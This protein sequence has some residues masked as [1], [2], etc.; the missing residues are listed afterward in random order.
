MKA[1]IFRRDATIRS[2][3]IPRSKRSRTTCW[4]RRRSTARSSSRRWRTSTTESRTNS[5]R[6]AAIS[7]NELKIGI[8]KATISLKFCGVVPG[9]AFKKKGVQR[10]LDCVVDYLPSPLDLPPDARARTARRGRSP[11]PTTTASCLALAFKL[12]SDPFVGKLV[13]FRVYS[14]KLSKGDTVYNPR[15]RQRERICRLMLIRADRARGHRR[16]LLRRHLR[17]GRHQEHHHR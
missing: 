2:G 5:S 16:R 17:H 10:L 14:G 4:R 13:F 1:Y 3:S 8:R 7:V 6:A 15:T 11:W 9:S 12:W